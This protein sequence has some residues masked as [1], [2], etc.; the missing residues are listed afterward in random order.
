MVQDRAVERCGA[1][2]WL[3]DRVVIARLG[4]WRWTDSRGAMDEAR[5]V[6]D[7]EEDFFGL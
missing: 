7:A 3:C 5:E 4:G 1:L 6:D 2:I